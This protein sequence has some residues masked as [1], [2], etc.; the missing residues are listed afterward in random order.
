MNLY[1]QHLALEVAVERVREVVELGE[2][3]ADAHA[4]V[5]RMDA[6]A[7]TSLAVFDE[8]RLTRGCDA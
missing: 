4:A 7:P 3:I 5:E 8:P 6:E 2:V 1:S